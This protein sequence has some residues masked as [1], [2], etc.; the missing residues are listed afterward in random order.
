MIK[1]EKKSDIEKILDKVDSIFLRKEKLNEEIVSY[2][3]YQML[4]IVNKLDK[5]S[6]SRFILY[7]EEAYGFYI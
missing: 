2:N 1:N 7:L 4:D 6:Q 5:D 3:V